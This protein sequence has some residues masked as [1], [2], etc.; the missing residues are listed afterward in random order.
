MNNLYQNNIAPYL[1]KRMQDNAQWYQKMGHIDNFK[2]SGADETIFY[3]IYFVINHLLHDGHTVLLLNKHNNMDNDNKNIIHDKCNKLSSW[4]FS[5]LS[6]VMVI[7]WDKAGQDF[8]FDEIFVQIDELSDD[9]TALNHYIHHIQ[10]NLKERYHQQSII[11]KNHNHQQDEQTLRQ[12]SEMMIHLLR[13]YYLTS[14]TCNQDLDKFI[15]LLYTNPFFVHGNDER[16]DKVVVFYHDDATLYLW[17]GR[18]YRAERELLSAI[19]E[20]RNSPIH[21]LNLPINPSL[22]LEQQQA[23]RQVAS[24]PFSI[25]TGGPGTGKTFTVAQIVLA[26]HHALL[27]MGNELSLALV[28]PTGKASQRMAESLQ[29]ALKDS[30]TDIILP[31][32]M[33]IHR[34][35]GIG[36]SGMPRYHTSNPLPHELIIVDEA[37]MLGT[38]LARHLLC[39]IK[40]GAR[41]IL[42]GDAH[43][44]S[45]VDAGAVLADL[46]CI[47]SLMA[48]RTHLIKSNRFSKDSGIGRL[49]E[50]INQKDDI[51]FDKLTTLIC[52]DSH[53]SWTDIEFL[54]AQS[55]F[56]QQQF[57]KNIADEYM[58]CDG[59]FALTKTLKK[60]FATYDDDEKQ[61]QLQALNECFN[62][63]RILNA[64]HIGN[65]GDELM[66]DF[67]ESLHRDYLKLPITKSP[68]YHGRPVMILKNRYDLGLF[69]GDIGICLQSGRQSHELSVYFGDTVKG[70]PI[71]LLDGD[72]ATTAY[73]MTVHK[74]QGSE[75]EKVAVVFCDDNERLLSKELIYTAI[76]RARSK[77]AIYST[78]QALLKAVNTPTIR[79]TGLLVHDDIKKQGD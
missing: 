27:D 44:L 31:E 14:I 50:L 71:N 33:T 5:V 6:P 35:L 53:L 61:K 54:K 25:I 78:K 46:C 30:Q 66:N 36:M 18:S 49:A 42:L 62:Q 11:S 67:I 23:I 39:A 38:E 32:P 70:L 55:L 17:L 58:V 4:Q 3:L 9:K 20:I 79:Q 68:W 21:T 1:A 65:C 73:A 8:N 26:L 47:P 77:V 63:Y 57:Y 12:L 75:F 76:T 10:N 56:L 22:N 24:E 2:F 41:V 43:Q 59:F 16:L 37:S 15:K 60:H 64:S 19:H 34:L 40:R 7:I 29:N 28:A 48:T 69:N 51:E 52:Q 72:I 13:F 74:S 45:A